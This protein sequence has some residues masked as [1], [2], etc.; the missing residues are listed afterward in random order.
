MGALKNDLISPPWFSS[1]TRQ[2]IMGIGSQA[3][4]FLIVYV[5]SLLTKIKKADTLSARKTSMSNRYI[6]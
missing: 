3:P 2:P 1:T 6:K 4:S 5:P